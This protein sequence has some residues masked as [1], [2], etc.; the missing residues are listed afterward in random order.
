MIR[1]IFFWVCIGA[2]GILYADPAFSKKEPDAEAM[3]KI[4]D[5]C[6]MAK[7]INRSDCEYY[8]DKIL[9]E[10]SQYEHKEKLFIPLSVAHLTKAY[11]C[12]K[13]HR[14]ES[15]ARKHSDAAEKLLPSIKEPEYHAHL[16]VDHCYISNQLKQEDVNRKAQ[17]IDRM[18]L[19]FSDFISSEEYAGLERNRQ[20][21]ML[22]Y[23]ASAVSI[24]LEFLMRNRPAGDEST[25]HFLRKTFA[26][27]EKL[28]A[29]TLSE[30]MCD[31]Y[32]LAAFFYKRKQ[33]PEKSFQ[34]AEKSLLLAEKHN[35]M[36]RRSSLILV[37]SAS[38]AKEYEKALDYCRRSYQF[39]LDHPP[40]R[41]ATIGNYYL[42]KGR[43][44][45]RMNDYKHAAE[46]LHKLE[47]LNLPA[48]FAPAVKNF[49][50]AMSSIRTPESN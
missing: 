39:F 45:Y 36:P 30:S 46:C 43:I 38:R 31:C 33:D 5:L 11:V 24:K 10:I 20:L 44:Y 41:D 47:Q 14:Q 49:Q 17:R 2:S 37:D 22:G 12:I 13:Q 8:A 16:L 4:E 1:L 34:Y 26:E 3:K 9:F 21:S 7:N 15:E 27:I 29:G 23:Y 18:I 50:K 6:I 32:D 19:Y 35:I 25:E 42:V 40:V 28:S 48:D